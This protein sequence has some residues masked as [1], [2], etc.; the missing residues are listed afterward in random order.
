MP[1]RNRNGSQPGKNFPT[2][3]LPRY[4]KGESGSLAIYQ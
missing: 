3:C 4:L 2:E 1:G